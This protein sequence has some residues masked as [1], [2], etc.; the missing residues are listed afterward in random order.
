MKRQATRSSLLLALLLAGGAMQ[1]QTG[2][3]AVNNNGAAP[4]PS[5]ILDVSTSLSG[6]AARG[7]LIPR[8][9]TTASVTVNASTDGMLVYQ[10]NAPAGFY[11]Y[12]A[13]IPAWVSLQTG[14]DGWEIYGNTLVYPVQEFFGTTDN[15]DVVFRTNN[16]E[17]M[18]LDAQGELGVNVGTPSERLDVGGALR[19]HSGPARTLVGP[20]ASPVGSNNIYSATD[21]L[22]VIEYQRD[23]IRNA[24]SVYNTSYWTGHRLLFPG[25]YGNIT[26]T[27]IVATGTSPN[28]GGWRRMN[29]DYTEVFNAPYTINGDATC[30]GTTAEIPS[31]PLPLVAANISSRAAITPVQRSFASPY[32]NNAVNRRSRL[33]WMFLKN[34][35]NAELNQANGAFGTPNTGAT[36][37]LCPGGG[38]INQIAFYVDTTAAALASVQKSM[39]YTIIVKHAPL[40]VSNLNGGYENTP[41]PAAGCV[42]QSVA[43]PRPA[44]VGWDVFNLTTPFVWDGVRNIIVEFSYQ[45]SLP[46]GGKAAPTKFY[47][48]PGSAPA[49]Q[50]TYG[51]GGLITSMTLQPTCANT[52]FGSAPTYAPCV[53]VGT[54]GQAGSYMPAGLCGS[55]SSTNMRPAIR[56]GGTVSAITS[57]VSGNGPYMQYAGGF[58][59]EDPATTPPWGWQ[60]SP[61]YAFKGPGTLSA[62]H[63]VYD[64]G[65]QL[66]D[67]VFDR[68]FDGKVR[69]EDAATFGDKRNLTIEEMSDHIATERHLPTIK[70]RDDWQ[71]NG[72][73]S[74]GEMANQ[75]WTTTETQTLYL[76]ELHD[77]LNVLEMLS[78]ERPLNETEFRTAKPVVTAME[79]LTEQQKAALVNDLRARVT[80]VNNR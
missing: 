76:T 61:Y 80:P 55:F 77:R 70:G 63:G 41:D 33:Q 2:N 6:S 27:G 10:T 60:T 57:F 53:T 69:P 49:N 42:I 45:Y 51:S 8:V 59:V 46:G 22:G 34:E 79:E 3:I 50:L 24:T 36:Q 66:N 23:T 62:Q 40:G 13:S 48:V 47:T 29:N 75:L 54:P 68:A 71:R 19:L 73:F 65:V 38:T 11:Y 20:P 4:D 56:F 32:E 58:V 35:L 21:G 78:N 39:S 9:T 43:Q 25:H 26:G 14:A 17:R 37:G 18:R 1:A 5:A 15:Q 72:G 28:S 30:T 52:L 44:N 64:N 7:M 31:A 67:H 12:N 16:V 74:L